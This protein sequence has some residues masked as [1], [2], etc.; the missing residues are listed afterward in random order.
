MPHQNYREG[1]YLEYWAEMAHDSPE[2]Q[3]LYGTAIS[4]EYNEERA[5]WNVTVKS[6]TTGKLYNV[7]I[8]DESDK[9]LECDAVSE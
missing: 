8:D 4:A 5:W 6:A 1:V 9:A 7:V 2:G 3:Y